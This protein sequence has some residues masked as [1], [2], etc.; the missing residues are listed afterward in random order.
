MVAHL[1]FLVQILWFMVEALLFSNI[2]NKRCNIVAYHID[3]I[4]RAM[5][6]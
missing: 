2:S 3:L 5:K 1:L 4:G 6:I